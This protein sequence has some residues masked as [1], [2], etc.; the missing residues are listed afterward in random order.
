MTYQFSNNQVSQVVFN[1]E[2]EVEFRHNGILYRT[3]G[4]PV[5]GN[6]PNDNF[7]TYVAPLIR[8]EDPEYPTSHIGE[9]SWDI[10]DP[11][12]DDEANA[13]D[14]DKFDVYF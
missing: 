10:I 7:S 6:S 1:K 13:C 14:W 3:V 9:V 12:T 8:P 2:G 4:Q 5:F 11:E